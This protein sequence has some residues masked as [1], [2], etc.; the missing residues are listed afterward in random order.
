MFLFSHLTYTHLRTDGLTHTQRGRRHT[1]HIESLAQEGFPLILW[2][3][4]QEAR[5]HTPP[6]YT[7]QLFKEHGVPRCK[8][9]LALEPHPLQLGWRSLDSEALGF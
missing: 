1:L 3:V 6:Q 2:E 5:Y 8:V 9:W 7:V 4:L